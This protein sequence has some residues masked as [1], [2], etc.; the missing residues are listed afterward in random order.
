LI[1]SRKASALLQRVMMK[2]GERAKS[3][4]LLR[5]CGCRETGQGARNQDRARISG[6][7]AA[8][9]HKV[10]HRHG[11]EDQKR[12]KIKNLRPEAEFR[13]KSFGGRSIA[14]RNDA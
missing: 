6:R 9:A 14:R 4:I 3:L 1:L 2:T 5:S 13:L 12:P 8:L 7:G 11:G 10:F